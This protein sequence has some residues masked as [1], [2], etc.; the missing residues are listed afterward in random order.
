MANSPV[1]VKG[2]AGQNT[3]DLLKA[4]EDNFSRV[5]P[6][7]VNSYDHGTIMCPAAFPFGYVAP[8]GEA[9]GATP[10]SV[11]EEKTINGDAAELKIFEALETF[12]GKTK[13][14]MF[15]LTR[16]KFKEFTKQV[17]QKMLP[18]DN[19]TL[20]KDLEG[21]VEFVIVHRRI[22]VILIE[23]K[24]TQ[25]FKK[26]VYRKA[27]TQLSS[28]E[29]IIQALL[30]GIGINI[31][32]HKVNAMPNA[33]RDRE[34]IASD[35][36]N[37]REDDV[38][39]HDAFQRWWRTKFVDS[40]V[41]SGSIEQEKMQKLIAILVGQRSALSCPAEVLSDIFKKIDS[42]SFLQRS[43]DK[44]A[45][46]DEPDVVKKTE[47]E[48]ELTTLAK[49][50]LFLNPEQ[51]R[52]WNGPHHQF[53]CGVTG[54]GKTIL[55]QFKALECA[56]KGEKVFVIVP[57]HLN[58]LYKNFF[59]INGVLSNVDVVSH[60]SC[61]SN[62]LR[63]N[64]SKKFHFFADEWQLFWRKHLE[65]G[66]VANSVEYT[67]INQTKNGDCY[68]WIAYDDKQ[69]NFIL[70]CMGI[71]NDS[72]FISTVQRYIQMFLDNRVFHH[73]ASLTTNMR[74]TV[75]VYNYWKSASRGDKSLNQKPAHYPLDKYWTYPVY[76]GHHICGPSV[77]EMSTPSPHSKDMLQVIKR[78]IETWAKDGKVY[79]FQ[80][81]A[82][83]VMFELSELK[84]SLDYE[85]R[86]E[87]IPV[88]EP[89]DN[90]NGVV[91]ELGDHSHSY[92]WPVV[93]AIC[94]RNAPVNYLM[95]SRAVTRLVVL[96]VPS[97]TYF[98]PE[99]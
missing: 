51:Q 75:Q 96:Y 49:Q 81:V 5:Y 53:F 77:T 4:C 68:Y 48:Q 66:I 28:G 76:L 18:A 86:K 31:P 70:E 20:V 90:C 11:I 36:I 17:L 16:F 54:S 39:G 40:E 14:P 42:Q 62:V 64:G 91:L 43:F 9:S 94:T 85:M 23:V 29:E 73:A 6:E 99:L 55:L 37:L 1:M 24:A 52:I 7:C 74:S 89:G 98:I 38:S 95:F 60:E 71:G 88:C 97:I 56:K 13:Q 12:G 93:I 15:V 87:D 61:V 26:K 45:T 22:G 47:N 84:E 50:F 80:K 19:P 3:S 25:T 82:V 67:L 10:L 59:E 35:F 79:T 21:E 8:R 92:E 83:L 34:C 63:R 32:V 41:K 65:G 27:K 30:H 58:N 57:S 46:M 44:H 33:V 72:H 2:P 69:W 78:E